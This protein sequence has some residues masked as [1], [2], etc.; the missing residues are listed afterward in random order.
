MSENFDN[1]KDEG[2]IEPERESEVKNLIK[3][4]DGLH[5]GTVTLVKFR[6]FIAAD[7]TKGEYVDLYI[8]PDECEFELK[9]SYPH[10]L[11]EGTLLGDLVERFG[12][13]LVPGAKVVLYK[14]FTSKRI[15]FLT[16]T[17]KNR[18]TG[19]SYA[20]IIRESVKPLE[21]LE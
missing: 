10:N 20:N 7:G 15:K 19:K 13:K 21:P 9:A 6:D 5:V 18:V 8:K 3:L 14:I 11:S 17:D 2:R 16:T 4:E 1:D 12:T